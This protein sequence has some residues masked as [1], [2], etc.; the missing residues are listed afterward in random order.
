[1]VG[2]QWHPEDSDADPAALAALMSG[3]AAE[4]ALRAGQIVSE[5]A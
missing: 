3:F 4:C 5:V 2:V 1:M